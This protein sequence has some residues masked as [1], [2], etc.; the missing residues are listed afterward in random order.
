MNKFNF[1]SDNSYKKILIRDYNE[2]ELAIKNNA[3][4]SAAVISGSIVEALLTDF[5]K[6]NG[7][8]TVK[9]TDNEN[10]PIFK[11]DGQTQ[12]SKKISEAGLN[13]LINECYNTKYISLKTYHLMHYLRD[14]RNYIHPD[15]EIRA[16]ISFPD[17][18]AEIFLTIVDLVLYEISEKSSEKFGQTSEQLLNYIIINND[19]NVLFHHLIEKSRSYEHIEDLLLKRIPQKI[20]SMKEQINNLHIVINDNYADQDDYNNIEALNNSTERLQY[21]YNLALKK[22]ENK[23][24]KKLA[25][26]YLRVITFENSEY[27]SIYA[28]IIVLKY[29]NELSLK[30]KNHI[31]DFYNYNLITV[32]NYSFFNNINYLIENYSN[33]N[34][35]GVLHNAFNRLTNVLDKNHV[36]QYKNLLLY[37]K[38]KNDNTYINQIKKIKDLSKKGH[39]YDEIGSFVYELL[40]GLSEETFDFIPF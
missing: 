16:E 29:T 34:M 24:I 8:T 14:Y 20:Y 9:V 39:S 17:T 35:F 26:E 19:S 28:N 5:L 31:L 15:K 32:N 27:K 18:S 33:I 38:N 36:E 13:N 11:K 10:K 21:C 30:D 4:K 7:L 1:I 6:D 3:I 37:V 40:S 23:S 22:I 25:L 12:A 2:I